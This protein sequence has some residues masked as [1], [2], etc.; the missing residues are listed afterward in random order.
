MEMESATMLVL[1][2]VGVAAVVA[3]NVTTVE[4]WP[5]TFVQ[6]NSGD[7]CARLNIKC[8]TSLRTALLL[9]P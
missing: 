1:V 7:V 2:I 3:A 5:P 9:M 4:T 8:N 6:E